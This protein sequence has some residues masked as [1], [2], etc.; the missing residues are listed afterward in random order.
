[1]TEPRQDEWQEDDLYAWYEDLYDDGSGYFDDY[2][3][4]WPE[5]W[6]EAGY[7][8][9]VPAAQG[10]GPTAEADTNDENFYKGKGKARSSSMGLG[11]STCGSKWHNTHSCPL[12][13]QSNKGKGKSFGKFKGLGKGFGKPFRNF[14]RGKGFGKKGK[15]YSNK[16]FGKRGFWSEGLPSSFRDYY[17]GSYLM[18]FKD[19]PKNVMTETLSPKA[20][21]NVIKLDSP[22]K[23]ELLTGKK[24]R[25][26]IGP[27][28]PRLRRRLPNAEF[29]RVRLQQL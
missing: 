1:M 15:S 10:D 19:A 16:G 5:Q 2:Q 22:Q 27:T 9:E 11:C 26:K 13:D 25:F 8:D 6:Y 7:E 21:T 14:G 17:G 3:N 24:V 18:N 20:M 23:E 29:P 28:L 12:N 4:D